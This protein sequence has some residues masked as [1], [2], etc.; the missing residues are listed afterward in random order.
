MVS[1]EPF[2]FTR[3]LNKKVKKK[4]LA[5]FRVCT[6]LMVSWRY[7]NLMPTKKGEGITRSIWY[8]AVLVSCF[9]NY[10]VITCD[11]K[12]RENLLFPKYFLIKPQMQEIA[13]EVSI[14]NWSRTSFKHYHNTWRITITKSK[15]TSKNSSSFFFWKFFEP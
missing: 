10:R 14:K 11:L 3:S 7:Q 5:Y 1:Q 6:S 12:L 8:L 2:S 4:H 15:F 9:E 13:S